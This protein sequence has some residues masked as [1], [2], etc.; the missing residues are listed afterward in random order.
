MSMIRYFPECL[1][2]D[3]DDDYSFL[4]S[5]LLQW[6]FEGGKFRMNSNVDYR[7]SNVG[8]IRGPKCDSFSSEIYAIRCYRLSAHSIF[9]TSNVGWFWCGDKK[10]ALHHPFDI[11]FYVVSKN[12]RW[13]TMS[14]V[15]LLF[16]L[17]IWTIVV[18]ITF[19][20]GWLK[21]SFDWQFG[22]CQNMIQNFQISGYLLFAPQSNDL[23][24]LCAHDG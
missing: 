4:A 24:V 17:W 8:R 22:D 12:A 23:C 3:D 9:P 18:W 7:C 14:H 2:D 11:W 15:L 19:S 1:N 5:N 21:C 20:S 13:L 10:W 16:Q 6:A